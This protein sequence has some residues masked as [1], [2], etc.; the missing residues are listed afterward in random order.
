MSKIRDSIVGLA[1]GDALGVPVEFKS[2]YELNNNPV[3]EMQGYGS[4]YV[5]KGCWSDDTSMTLATI[6]SI[7]EQQKID[8]NDIMMKFCEWY[9]YAKYTAT[10]VFFDIGI[11]TSKSLKKYLQGIPPLMCGG[12][13]ERDNGNGSLMRILP[14]V[15][16]SYTNRLSEKQEM[17]LI[18]NMSSLTHRHEISRLG[19]KI[20]CDFIKSLLDTSDKNLALETIRLK[21][22]Y[23]SKHYSIDTLRKY[24]RIFDPNFSSLSKE[25]IKSSGFVVDTLES[26]IWC[27]MNANS[28]YETVVL[29]VNLGDDTD[30]VG[31]ITGSMAGLLYGINNIPKNWI[32]NLKNINYLD[33]LVSRFEYT[34]DSKRGPKW[35]SVFKH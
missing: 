13:G 1:I 22:D 10:G 12:E 23:Y 2:R 3:Q 30:T 26:S 8:Y 25:E 34:L 27:L 21:F 4:H 14:A 17:E 35:R 7:V 19:C 31:A 15:L 16:Y 9:N 5:P 11:S 18:N 28:F 20:Y 6:D 24:I 33:D 29:A 32:E